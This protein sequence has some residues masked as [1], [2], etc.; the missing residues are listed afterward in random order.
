MALWPIYPCTLQPL[1]CC[2]LLMIWAAPRFVC[3]DSGGR[4]EEGRVGGG[5]IEGREVVDL[6]KLFQICLQNIS[7]KIPY[8]H[9][10]L[11]PYEASLPP[12]LPFK[13]SLT[14]IAHAHTG[15][16]HHSRHAADTKRVRQLPR[17]Y[18]LDQTSTKICRRRR[19]SYLPGEHL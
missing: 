17:S 4:N 6:S 7:N 18:S 16:D 15:S 2:W 11:P 10:H 14:R 5:R 19:R 9:T 8:N 13:A 12:Q 3:G 1:G